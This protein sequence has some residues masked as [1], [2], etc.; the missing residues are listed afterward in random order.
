MANQSPGKES[1][2]AQSSPGKDSIYLNLSP[3]KFDESCMNCDGI[4]IQEFT[5]SKDGFLQEDSI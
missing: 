4:D 2:M 3:M 1:S 5:L